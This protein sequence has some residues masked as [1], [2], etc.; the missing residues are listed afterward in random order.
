[1]KIL[2]PELHLGRITRFVLEEQ[3]GDIQLAEDGRIVKFLFDGGRAF[4]RDEIGRT[5]FGSVKLMAPPIMYEEVYFEIA[6]ES[7]VD[8]AARWGTAAD[9]NFWGGMVGRK[10][11]DVV[12]GVDAFVTNFADVGKKLR[13]VFNGSVGMMNPRGPFVLLHIGSGDVE[14]VPGVTGDDIVAIEYPGVFM[15]SHQTIRPVGAVT[16][17]LPEQFDCPEFRGVLVRNATELSFVP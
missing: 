1:M 17:V 7:G 9:F 6:Q 16:F 11:W 14:L 10:T 12:E 2:L 4:H 15:G 8:V 3:A 13:V 5:D